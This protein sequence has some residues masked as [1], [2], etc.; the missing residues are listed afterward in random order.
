M[1][2]GEVYDFEINDEFHFHQTAQNEPP[3]ADRIKIIDKYYS[4][5]E[6]TVF[7]V[8]ALDRYQTTIPNNIGDPLNYFFFKDTSTVYYTNLDSLINFDFEELI[9][10]SDLYYGDQY[11]DSLINDFSYAVGGDFEPDI[12]KSRFGKGIGQLRSYYYSPSGSFPMVVYDNILFYYKKNG[13]ECGEPD[14]TTGV[15]TLS[16]KPNSFTIYPN[17]TKSIL[18]IYNQFD[19]RCF[20]IRLLDSRG[21]IVK[22]K[23]LYGSLNSIDI[24]DLDN[25]IYFLEII[26]KDKIERFKILK[27]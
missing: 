23:T 7:Y 10:E 26:L 6:D 25:G 2:I 22:L 20:K 1:T 24:N 4:A 12:Y 19:M 18:N 3:N 16:S 17:P 11:C 14:L 15:H 27:V 9:F 8:K 5:D 21:G 13:L